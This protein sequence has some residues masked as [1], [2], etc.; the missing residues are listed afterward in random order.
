MIKFRQKEY[1]LPAALLTVGRGALG[2]LNVAGNAAAV[3]GIIQGSQQMKQAEEQAAQNR[4]ITKALNNIAEN[5]KN[6]PQAAQQAADVIGQKQFA[7]IN[8][9]GMM[10]AAK[11]SKFL[12][13]AKGLGKDVW[14]IT[15]EHKN[16]L[17]GGTLAGGAMAGAGYLTDRAIQADMKKS[18]IPLQQKQ[19][20]Q[21]VYAITG[22]IMGGLKKAGK[23]TWDAAKKNKKMIAGM[24]VL[25]SAPTALGYM[26][27]KQQL[28]DQVEHTRQKT[29][30]LK[31]KTFGK[32]GFLG[33]AA[34]GAVNKV[35][36]VKNWQIWKT[37]GQTTLGF[38]SNMSM[39]GGREGVSKFGKRLEEL[40]GR[41][42]S[43]WSKKAGR[44]IQT[45]PKTALAA[46]IPVGIGVM[47]GT[48]DAGEKLVRK[49]AE[50]VDKNAYAYQKS[51]EEQIQ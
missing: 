38:L 42:G 28:K 32:F 47:S 18:G 26:A 30:S 25:G 4:K 41:S 51:K 36:G 9:G 34:K 45:H 10:K 31:L 49:G 6:N 8:L 39:G 50:A 15:K 1:V 37:P 2:A 46:S 22:S 29:Y 17:I 3:G 11:N 48:W 43:E 35:K 40:G 24:A 27:E 7:R 44:F 20:E 13:N 19:E 14:T 5:A 33:K 23:V 12:K 16:G 21:R